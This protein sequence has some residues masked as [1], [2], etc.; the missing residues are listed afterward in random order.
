MEFDINL[1]AFPV[2]TKKAT[3]FLEEHYFENLIMNFVF[4]IDDDDDN[5][6]G[7]WIGLT[8]IC[9]PD[10]EHTLHG[11]DIFR[12]EAPCLCA[13]LILQQQRQL[14]L[15]NQQ[16]R[17]SGSLNRQVLQKKIESFGKSISGL[18]GTIS[19]I[20]KGVV[21][22]IKKTKEKQFNFGDFDVTSDKKQQRSTTKSALTGMTEEGDEQETNKKKYTRRAESVSLA[23]QPPTPASIGF[24]PP[25]GSSTLRIDN[26]L[27]RPKLPNGQTILGWLEPPA[28]DLTVRSKQYM[29]T[30]EK[31]PSP[32]TLYEC[33]Q[34]DVFRSNQRYPNMA[35][36]VILPKVEDY[37]GKDWN[38]DGVKTWKSPDIFVVSISLPT[39]RPNLM[40]PTIDGPGHTICMYF[41]MRQETR[42]ILRRVTAK[43]YVPEQEKEG[44]ADNNAAE[45]TSKICAVKLFEKWCQRAP[46]DSEFFPR[47]KLIPMAKNWQDIGLP[48]WMA[49]YNAK[50]V[51]I[52]RAGKTGFLYDQYEDGSSCMEFDISLHPF[53]FV[54]KQ[55]MCFVK[56]NLFK[57]IVST[58]GFVIEGRDEEELPECLIGVVQICDADP[59]H[60]LQG[61]DIFSGKAT[62]V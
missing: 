25:A 57:K 27:V 48:G 16:Q 51:L 20:H 61:E 47:F 17:Q 23:P 14:M 56:E 38:K 46:V 39:Y 24:K 59:D 31:I 3:S 49:R 26:E 6:N 53:P 12:G 44:G 18:H 33:V 30:K 45:E 41:M 19:Y 13:P 34:A 2:A 50:P 36:R 22:G 10:P 37:R 60:T 4:A 1:H 35:S 55:A 5:N 62:T 11:E 58:F 9:Y 40:D 29:A 42:D 54:A 28:A 15:L 32:G 52:K 21:E 7:C 43:D 8:Q